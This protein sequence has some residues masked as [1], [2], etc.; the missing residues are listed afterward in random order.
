MTELVLGFIIG[1]MFGILLS[2]ALNDSLGE[3]NEDEIDSLNARW[4]E[5]EMYEIE[6]H[7]HIHDND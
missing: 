5:E 6:D 3:Y 7:Y 4:Y 2:D 1:L